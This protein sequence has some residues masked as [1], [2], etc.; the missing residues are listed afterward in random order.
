MGPSAAANPWGQDTTLGREGENFLSSSDK[1]LYLLFDSLAVFFLL[2]FK[3]PVRCCHFWALGAKS[4][5]FFKIFLLLFVIFHQVSLPL[6]VFLQLF[7]T[8][9][10]HG[11]EAAAPRYSPTKTHSHAST[12]FGKKELE[13][14]GA[15]P[16]G[17]TPGQLA[18]RD[19]PG[20][21]TETELCRGGIVWL[22][23][24]VWV[25]WVV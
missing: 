5:Q 4:H 8:C 24:V 19:T 20:R 25:V 7:L 14:A 11:L 23:W 12:E 2:C 1:G 3:S 13:W 9:L 15:G 22:V 10:E 16:G 21:E 18:R 6:G 17:G